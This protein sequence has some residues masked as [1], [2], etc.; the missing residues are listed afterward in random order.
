MFITQHATKKVSL[1]ACNARYNG[2]GTVQSTVKTNFPSVGRVRVSCL[3]LM[4]P[5]IPRM[6]PLQQKF[7]VTWAHG[8]ATPIP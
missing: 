6:W 8:V 1:L 4:W 2:P 3:Y 5:H 7:L